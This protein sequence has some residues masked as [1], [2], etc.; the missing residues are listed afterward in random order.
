MHRYPAACTDA[1]RADLPCLDRIPVIEPDPCETFDPAGLDGIRLQRSDHRFFQRS[2]KAMD[3]GEMVIE[4][5][6]R[7]SDD[8]PW[9]VIGDIAAAIDREELD[10]LLL[11]LLF[12]QQKMLLLPALAQC[13][14]MRMLAKKQMILCRHLPIL[15]QRTVRDLPIDGGLKKLLLEV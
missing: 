8:L 2:K 13:V 15:R 14:H 4:I 12:I 1:E 6:D 5:E 9:T 7:I 11:Q 3:V 10:T